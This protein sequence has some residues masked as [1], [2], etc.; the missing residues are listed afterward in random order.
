[1]SCVTTNA[2]RLSIGDTLPDFCFE[3]V[4][5]G[6]F[7]GNSL[8][9]I[10]APLTIIDFWAVWCTA[11]SAAF[12]KLDT[13]QHAFTGQLQIVLVNNYPHTK[14]NAITIDRF[15]SGYIRKYPGFSVPVVQLSSEAL[16]QSFPFIY[17]PHYV[18]LGPGRRILGMTG[19]DALTEDNIRAIL[20][21]SVPLLP[22]KN[23][24]YDLSPSNS[25]K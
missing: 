12:P 21:G 1:M 5:N 19:T 10:N 18:W 7:S 16:R 14:D 23:D 15:I 4:G 24:H 22:L 17:I 25:F 13:L 20:G 3:P 6:A 9:S 11:C 2:Q 8:S